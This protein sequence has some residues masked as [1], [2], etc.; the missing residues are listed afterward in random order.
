[1]QVI[2]ADMKPQIQ[3]FEPFLPTTDLS[4]LK[5]FISAFLRKVFVGDGAS[6]PAAASAS[7]SASATA[8]ATAAD[9]K[10]D[11]DDEKLSVKGEVI[12]VIGGGRHLT[13]AIGRALTDLGIGT[14][15]KGASAGAGSGGGVGAEGEYDVRVHWVV[16]GIHPQVQMETPRTV[17]ISARTG[18]LIELDRKYPDELRQYVF[19]LFSE[20]S[21]DAIQQRITRQSDPARGQAIH[22]R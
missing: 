18:R 3:I 9:A 6:A 8:T 10:G 12:Y 16:H 21:T 7:A 5:S 11:A 2:G 15:K 14:G 20:G 19:G 1:V 17:A 4:T 13:T 22:Y